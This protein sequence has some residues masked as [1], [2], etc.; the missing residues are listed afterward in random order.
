MILEVC[1]DGLW[2]LSFGLSHF[3]GHGSWLVCEVALGFIE[4]VFN[5]S[6]MRE[7]K[8]M[9]D[10]TLSYQDFPTWSPNPFIFHSI[11]I[12]VQ[13]FICMNTITPKQVLLLANEN[14][15]I[16]KNEGL[17]LKNLSFSIFVS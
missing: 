4:V 9:F 15:F 6:S 10:G 2:T 17:P 13:Y 12:N 1:W 8:L 11:H 7:F 3:H 5:H 16:L 14:L